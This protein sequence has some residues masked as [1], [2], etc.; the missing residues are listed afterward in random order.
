MK[1]AIIVLSFIVFAG[2]A[3]LSLP[4][5]VSAAP[6][7]NNNADNTN[8]NQI[9]ND[10]RFDSCADHPGQPKCAV[11]VPEFG[12]LPGVIAAVASTGSYLLLKKRN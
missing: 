11:S 8:G 1:N 6:N 7:T 4:F 10:Q 2:T 5:S 9:S 3:S 12:L